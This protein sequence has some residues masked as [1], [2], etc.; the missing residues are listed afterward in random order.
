MTVI[1]NSIPTYNM[2]LNISAYSEHTNWVKNLGEIFV[3]VYVVS[4][5]NANINQKL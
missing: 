4:L 2:N 1:A 3:L 5:T